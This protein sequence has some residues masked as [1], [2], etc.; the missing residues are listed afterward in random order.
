MQK[1]KEDLQLKSLF[2]MNEALVVQINQSTK[3]HQG[4]TPHGGI[5]LFLFVKDTKG[6]SLFS[7][8]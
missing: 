4:I 6:A 1:L 2:K 7:L 5:S 8:C 3:D